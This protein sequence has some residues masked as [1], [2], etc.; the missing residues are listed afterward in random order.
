ML[1]RGI[2][3]IL[4]CMMM[5]PVAHAQGQPAIKTPPPRLSADLKG[6]GHP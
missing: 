1:W 5:S 6:F 2:I 4:L 3:S